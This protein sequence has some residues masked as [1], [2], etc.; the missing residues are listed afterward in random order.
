MSMPSGTTTTSR[1]SAS[2]QLTLCHSRARPSTTA[3]CLR[4]RLG[5]LRD[6]EA[7]RQLVELHL[8]LVDAL[9]DLRLERQRVGDQ[10]ALARLEVGAVGQLQPD[11][12]RHREQHRQHQRHPPPRAAPGRARPSTTSSW[13]A[14]ASG[15]ARR[16]EAA[17]ERVELQ[18]LLGDAVADLALER[19][20]IGDQLALARLEVGAVGQLQPHRDR[21]REQ[22]RQH[23]RHPPPR[24]APRERARPRAAH[25][26]GGRRR[27]RLGQL[28]KHGGQSRR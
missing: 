4:E 26:R 11:R 5:R 28:G 24:A 25:R 2:T 7:A 21:H 19:Q 20:R 16:I 1:V 9:G 23:Q 6:V 17:R 15:G 3:S 14:S 22:H 10:L 12:H 18:L 27:G 8:L 13:R